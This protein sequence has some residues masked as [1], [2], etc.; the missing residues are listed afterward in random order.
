MTAAPSVAV[1][2]TGNPCR[3]RRSC[4]ESVLGQ[5]VRS[6]QILVVDNNSEDDTVAVAE[7]LGIRTITRGPEC[8]AQRK[9]WQVRSADVVCL[10]DGDIVLESRVVA[11][12]T[13]VLAQEPWV[14][15]LLVRRRHRSSTRKDA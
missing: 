5:S 15:A 4:L 10:V 12:A 6:A 13:A 3:T 14:G 9:G 8:S 11:D 7:K 1:V 2:P